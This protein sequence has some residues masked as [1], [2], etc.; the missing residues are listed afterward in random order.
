MKFSGNFLYTTK[1]LRDLAVHSHSASFST[2]R[3]YS[4]RFAVQSSQFTNFFY[5]SVVPYGIWACWSKIL[6]CSRSS[7]NLKDLNELLIVLMGRHSE[8]GKRFI[9]SVFY[10]CMWYHYHASVSLILFRNKILQL[11]NLYL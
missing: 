2:N 8:V 4:N 9:L 10:A 1:L 11:P 7:S 5:Q 6:E 3:F